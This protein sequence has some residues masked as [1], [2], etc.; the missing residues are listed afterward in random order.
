MLTWESI[1]RL[2]DRYSRIARL[3]PAILAVAPCV[4][5]AVILLPRLVTSMAN[6]LITLLVVVSALYL[7]SA[8]ARSRGKAIEPELL[9]RW[10]GWTTTIFLRHRDPTVD[11]ITK[12]RYHQELSRLCDGLQFPTS[13]EEANDPR[14]AD[15]IYRSATRKLIEKRRDA[16][17]T[18]LHYENESYGFRR[19]MLGLRPVAVSLAT[20]AALGAATAWY[21]LTPDPRSVRDIIEYGS[22]YPQFPA[23]VV[24]DLLDLALWPLFVR[25]FFVRQAAEEYAHALFRTLDA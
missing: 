10:G 1:L 21:L 5:S 23:L 14:A 13:N 4:W 9:R 19:N 8:I 17:Y 22:S 12:A 6:S 16:K 18:H 15:D 24:A 11:A 2:F 25:E 20:L 7:I 3:Y